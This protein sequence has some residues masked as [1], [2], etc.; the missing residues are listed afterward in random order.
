VASARV[1]TVRIQVTAAAARIRILAGELAAVKN[2]ES[3]EIEPAA[4]AETLVRLTADGTTLAL[5][6]V[7]EQN[8]RLV[9]KI[10]RLGEEP[11]E[12]EPEK[13]RL[14]SSTNR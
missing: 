3:I 4:G 14:M 5:A 13:W 8:G 12:G 7:E 1:G 6:S 11:A 9:G 2:G 10:I